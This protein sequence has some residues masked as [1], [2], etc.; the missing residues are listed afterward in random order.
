VL[1]SWRIERF[2]NTGL[3]SMLNVSGVLMN[4]ITG[5]CVQNG[6]DDT[7]CLFL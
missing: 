3:I 6:A 2:S 7:L 4:M 1:G 5:L